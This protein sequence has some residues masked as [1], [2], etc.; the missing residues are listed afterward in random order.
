MSRAEHAEGRRRHTWPE[1]LQRLLPRD[2]LKGVSAPRRR[3]IR[4]AV[5]QGEAVRDPADAPYAVA[6]AVRMQRAARR[7]WRARFLAWALVVPAAIWWYLQGGVLLAAA[8]V[9]VL[10]VL[11]VI[12]EAWVRRAAP[13]AAEAERRNREIARLHRLDL[14]S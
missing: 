9:I 3:E 13:N 12:V 5:R 11:T 6:L 1:G 4:Q 7:P 14:D 10:V 8:V 2:P